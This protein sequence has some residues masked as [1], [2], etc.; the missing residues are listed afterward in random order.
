MDLMAQLAKTKKDAHI[1]AVSPAPKRHAVL[2]NIALLLNERR[3]EIK[4][5]QKIWT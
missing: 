1:F 5:M 3:E 4:K 2:S